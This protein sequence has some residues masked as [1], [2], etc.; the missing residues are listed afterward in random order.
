MNCITGKKGQLHYES[1]D[2]SSVVQYKDGTLTIKETMG[3]AKIVFDD[4]NKEIQYEFDIRPYKL[5]N[6]YKA[7]LKMALAILPENEFNNYKIMTK[8]LFEDNL[9][10]LEIFHFNFYPGFNRFGLTTIGWKR[11]VDEL[12]I[13]S[14]QFA[15]MN[16]DFLLQ[17]PVFSDE[18]IRA[19]NEHTI[20][21]EKLTTPTP[22]DHSDIGDV[23]SFTF[24][25][26][27]TNITPAQKLPIKMKY[28]KIE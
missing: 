19:N 15:I 27:D 8:S 24:A 28:E 3:A 21:I 20:S 9:H 4:K 11:I 13:P 1:F 14:Y 12:S 7:L 5:I 23:K 22:F 2:K 17:I 26:K 25:V 6:V 16:G 10:G 18:D